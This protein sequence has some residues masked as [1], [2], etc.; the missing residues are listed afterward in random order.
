MKVITIGR[1]KDNNNIVIEDNN[2]S[3][4]HL[5]IINDDNGNYYAIDLDSTN[6]TFVNGNRITGKVQLHKGDTIVIGN[7]TLSWEA[8]FN[9][10]SD[11]SDEDDKKPRPSNKK[12]YVII[13]SI[14]ICVFIGVI[15]IVTY[16]NKKNEQYKEASFDKVTK[17][18]SEEAKEANEARKE[19]ENKANKAEIESAAANEKAAKAEQE[20]AEIKAKAEKEVD[21]A[22]K[23]AADAEK[24][25]NE[26]KAEAEFANQ[27]A[28][29]AVQEAAD[30]KAKAEKEVLEAI[31][32]AEDAENAA[33]VAKAEAE[34]SEQ[35]TGVFY[36]LLSS[37]SNVKIKS[38][39]EDMKLKGKDKE[40]LKN[41][42]KNANNEGKKNVIKSIKNIMNIPE[43]TKEEKQVQQSSGTVQALG[44][45]NENIE[46]TQ[47]ISK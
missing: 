3:R 7:T 8:Y 34:E 35:L 26:A 1:S 30:T 11:D 13:S 9:I 43:P 27:K 15:T 21:A 4:S 32:K 41:Y 10:D 29:D 37:L 28:A 39:C 42:F 20:A 33:N 16:N 36:E 31:K 23:K 22:N 45:E 24:A 46:G 40:A 47:A 6:G 12:L 2:V 5:Q 18:Y 25:A 19:A 17:A 38:V 14:L 44:Q